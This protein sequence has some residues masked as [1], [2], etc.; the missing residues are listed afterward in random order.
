MI[1]LCF[2]YEPVIKGSF[3]LDDYVARSAEIFS[4]FVSI[5]VSIFSFSTSTI[6]VPASFS[7]I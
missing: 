3:N 2:I 5:P 4:I 6:Y 1:W 7:P